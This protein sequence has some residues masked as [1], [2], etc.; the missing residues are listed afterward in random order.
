MPLML[1]CPKLFGQD[2]D[3]LITGKVSFVNSKNIYVKFEN[4]KNINIGDTL[5]FLNQEKP[6]LL[7]QNKSSKSVICISL[8]NCEIEKGAI[9]YHNYTNND[10][11]KEEIDKKTIIIENKKIIKN[12]EKSEKELDAIERI[13]GKLSVASYSDFKPSNNNS[14]RM[15][16]RFSINAQNI[17]NS[18]ISLETY[19][20]YRQYFQSKDSAVRQRENV[21]NIYNLALKYD[22]TPTFLLTVGRKINN[23]TSSLGAI[24]GL[25]AEK[26]FGNSYVGIIAGFR[27][28]INDY[29]FN[30]DLLEYGG[31]FGRITNNQNFQSQTTLGILQQTNKGLIDRRYAYFQHS[32]AVLKKL[33]LFSSMEFDLYNKVDT[34]TSNTIDLTNLYASAKYKFSRKLDLMVSYD[35]RKRIL[36][37][38]TFQ[39]EIERLLND[40]EAR[41]G[42]R[43]RLNLKPTKF[44]YAG[45]SYSKRFQSSTQNKSN[46][47]NA[48][49]SSSKIPGIGGRLSINFNKNTSNYLE[50]TIISIRHSREL[51]LNKLSADFYFRMV[52]YDYFNEN[53]TNKQN[54]YG[55]SLS[56]R[57]SKSLKFNLFGEMSVISGEKNNYRIN[58]SIS[59][60]F[61]NKRKTKIF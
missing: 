14:H 50:S 60:R 3:I 58:T 39:T 43:L 28:D 19:L 31:Y 44:L 47:I 36:Y 18:K 20:N 24:D 8:F 38:E 27:P 59:K 13:R 23:K 35:S 48:Y 6:C 45:A 9:V 2:K 37:Y 5:K 57:I 61:K 25:Q 17:D 46:N 10:S 32:S 16:Y 7:V 34:L 41:Q 29:N 30:S 55:S 21:F 54:Y 51:I 1:L 4:T 15:M 49:M 11:K 40:N 42:L 33:F 52:D 22:I 12:I 53:S 26:F 56:L